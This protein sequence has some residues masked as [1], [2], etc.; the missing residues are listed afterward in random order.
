MAVE[1]AMPKLGLTME[2]G[3][4]LEWLV[5]SGSEVAAGDAVLV[6]TCDL[7]QG[8]C[9]Y[10]ATLFRFASTL[11]GQY[12]LRPA[13]T[14]LPAASASGEWQGAAALRSNRTPRP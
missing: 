5:E 8:A 13:V 12:A 1:F 11:L 3:T 2:A 6:P 9:A 14:R 7:V 10:T 4:I